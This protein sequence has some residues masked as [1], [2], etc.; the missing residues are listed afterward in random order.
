MSVLKIVIT[1]VFLVS[2]NNANLFDPSADVASGGSTTGT[3]TPLSPPSGGEEPGTPQ[4]PDE[5][6]CHHP[7][8]LDYDAS[9]WK[10]IGPCEFEACPNSEYAEFQLANIFLE[11]IERNGGNITPNNDLC[12]TKI[13]GYKDDC[14]HPLASNNGSAEKCVFKAC[15]TEGFYEHE[16][17]LSL[18]KLFGDAVSADPLECKTPYVYKGCTDSL[19]LNYDET[20]T[21]DD[22]TCKYKL[23][24]DSRSD[25]YGT[26]ENQALLEALTTYAATHNL[27]IDDLVAMNT[28]AYQ[29][30][31]G[32]K[33]E[34]AIGYNASADKENGS[35][36]W[37]GCLD[38]YSDEFSADL[39]AT[40]TAYAAANGGTDLSTY[41]ETNTCTE[42]PVLGCVIETAVNH[43]SAATQ[44]DGS[45]K[46]DGCIEIGKE[47]FS[48]GLLETVTA[49]ASMHQVSRE[50]LIRNNTCTVK[51]VLGCRVQGAIGYDS[52]AN[53]D[54]GSC[55][56]NGC[57]ESDKN[58]YS[59]ELLAIIQTYI[60]THGGTP[61]SYIASNTCTVKP[62]EG[63]MQRKAN[64][65]NSAAQ[66]D[67]GSC[68]WDE[69]IKGAMY[70]GH[71]SLI[72]SLITQYASVH[73]GNPQ[74]YI[75]P[76]ANNCKLIGCMIPGALNH[77]PAAQVDKGSCK[78][79]G[80]IKGENYAI[81]NPQLL[82]LIS[83]YASTH[84]GSLQSY[85]GEDTCKLKGCTHSNASV[86]YN[87]NAEVE[88]GSCKW[89]GCINGD[90]SV[91]HSQTLLRFLNNYA[92]T[93]GGTAQ[94]YIHNDLCKEKG[95]M[96]PRANN[97][98]AGAQVDDGSC[99]WNGC[100]ESSG[101]KNPDA[102]L[103]SIIN[104]YISNHGGVKSDYINTNTCQVFTQGCK[105]ASARNTTSPMPDIDNGSCR[106]NAC[107]NKCKTGY[108]GTATE[109]IIRAYSQRHNLGQSVRTNTC[110]GVNRYQCVD[111]DW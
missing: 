49:Y 42:K 5:V 51:E 38:E 44:G 40:I 97:P 81:H 4:I 13:D 15:P 72:L 98:T 32:C 77:N 7:A 25:D 79:R 64:N 62:V 46:W 84:N 76:E 33:V 69:C 29:E 60:T 75:N 93:F 53:K 58:G 57:I 8:A 34:G 6:A 66:V 27:N 73:G 36:K 107:L 30:V 48:Q 35:C 80:C 102:Q 11:Y 88:N 106:W 20:A 19:A 26:T 85:I 52:N 91:G 95:C 2:C 21:L 16:V 10:Q 28:C 61:A 104:T 47:G 89:N 70:E 110:R 99:R 105:E 39:L 92:K 54:D 24:T 59:A 18:K 22:M 94:N 100:P 63:C 101:V 82:A 41:I 1:I 50:S 87:P 86:G 68:Q 111:S 45:C 96:A 65:Y 90:V 9:S 55:K 71:D 74:D 78:W 43:N 103:L 17:Y 31:L 56:W 14:T 12:V 67:N 109:S 108:V 83:T 23:C 3:T 37:N